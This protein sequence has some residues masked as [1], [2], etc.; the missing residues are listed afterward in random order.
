MSSAKQVQFDSGAVEL[1]SGALAS[2]DGF[3][4]WAVSHD[5]PERGHV[6]FL[7]GEIYIDM[8]PEEIETHNKVK[9]AIASAL[10]ALNETRAL[11]EF[12]PDGTLLTNDVANRCCAGLWIQNGAATGASA[13]PG[14]SA[15]TTRTP[16]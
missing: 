3:R 4:A 6:S 15:V 1:P 5:Y 8:S 13:V 9:A 10:F 7:N 14:S 12:Y 2:L 11:G 16:S